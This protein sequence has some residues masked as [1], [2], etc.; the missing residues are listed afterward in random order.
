M[1]SFIFKQKGKKIQTRI[2]CHF[3]SKR[4]SD[5]SPEILIV[6]NTTIK[7]SFLKRVRGG[8]TRWGWLT[9]VKESGFLFGRE[10]DAA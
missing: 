5:F 8:E 1:V 7:L 3:C 2:I 4:L 6:I 9:V 10:Q